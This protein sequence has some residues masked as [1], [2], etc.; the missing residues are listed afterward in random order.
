MTTRASL[1][2]SSPK[3]ARNAMACK[4]LHGTKAIYYTRLGASIITFPVALAVATFSFLFNPPP[5][6]STWNTLGSSA[7]P[8]TKV[9]LGRYQAFAAELAAPATTG[10]DNRR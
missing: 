4:P 5:H 6:L 3:H 1:R 8:H 10:A 7:K 2:A 9:T